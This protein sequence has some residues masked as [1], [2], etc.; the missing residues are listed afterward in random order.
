MGTTTAPVPGAGARTAGKAMLL[1]GIIALLGSV[2]VGVAQVL[3]GYGQI[4]SL[5]EIGTRFT[6]SVELTLTAGDRLVLYRDSAADPPGCEATG[7]SGPIDVEEPVSATDESGWTAIGFL[8][9]TSTGTYTVLCDTPQMM[10]A[11][12]QEDDLPFGGVMLVVGGYLAGIIG[13]AGSLLLVIV[14]LV[15]LL[16]ARHHGRRAAA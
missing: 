7:P 1:I 2:V 5:D 16:A 14:G 6:G 4:D 11:A 8:E 3:I 10:L 9:A 13:G 15:V 12:E